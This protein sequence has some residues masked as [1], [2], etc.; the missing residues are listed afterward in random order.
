[1]KSKEKI[2]EKRQAILMTA[3]RLFVLKG[4][5]GTKT[6]EISSAVGISEGLLFHYFPTKE[7]LL[8]ELVKMGSWGMQTPMQVPYT[9][10]IEY[11]TN[12]TESALTYIRQQPTMA[13]MFALMAQVQRTEGIPP[14]IKEMAIA[15]DTIGA[16]AEIIV[17]GQQEGSIRQGN[18]LALSN[19]Y[20]CTI[21]GIMEQYAAHPDIPLPQAEWIVSMMKGE[22]KDE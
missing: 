16:A 8:E 1:M 14:N 17:K 12:F 21:Q 15:V 22:V 13:Y 4:Y 3:M 5:A 10:A 7:I 18:P 20:W 9:H 2:E 11:F 19:L 6:K